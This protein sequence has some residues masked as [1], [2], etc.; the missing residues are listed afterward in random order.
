MNFTNDYLVSI[1]N[2]VLTQFSDEIKSLKIP[3]FVNWENRHLF[4][5][6]DNNV[7]F[8]YKKFFGADFSKNIDKSLNPAATV[9]YAALQI[10]YYMGFSEVVIIGLDHNFK[11]NYKKILQTKGIKN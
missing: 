8:I 1:N 2:L 4:K 5:D 9:T 6:L 10:I 11:T 7:F 3:K